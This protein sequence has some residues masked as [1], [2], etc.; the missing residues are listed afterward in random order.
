MAPGIDLNDVYTNVNCRSSGAGEKQSVGRLMDPLKLRRGVE[1]TILGEDE[2]TAPIPE[3]LNNNLLAFFVLITVLALG[4]FLY[5]LVRAIKAR[6][7]QDRIK[8]E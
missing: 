2:F 6:R 3:V 7:A 5:T 1:E 4:W 8:S